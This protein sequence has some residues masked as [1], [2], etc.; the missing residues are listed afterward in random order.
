MTLKELF[1][2]ISDEQEVNMHGDDFDDFT[3]FKATLEAV[4]SKK[5]FEMKVDCVEASFDGKLKVW[6]KSA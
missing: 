1:S 5:A 4:L 2:V 3:A 6:V